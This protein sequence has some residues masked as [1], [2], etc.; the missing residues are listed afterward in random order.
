MNWTV[1]FIFVALLITI[2]SDTATHLYKFVKHPK[3]RGAMCMDGSQVGAYIHQGS[4]KNKDKFLIHLCGG[5]F[6]GDDNVD[7]TV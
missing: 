6:C 5:G 7:K 1:S 2:N 4:G 3:D